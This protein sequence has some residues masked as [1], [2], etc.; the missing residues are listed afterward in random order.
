[1]PHPDL[2]TSGAGLAEITQVLIGLGRRMRT[3]TD[4]SM[5]VGV[6]QAGAHHVAGA[7]WASVSVVHRG[8]FRTLAATAPVAAQADALQHEIGAGP[9]VDPA[10]GEDFYRCGD[11]A[12]QR[13]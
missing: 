1:M 5:L 2:H 9:G 10:P 11:L 4:G 13:R 6:A 3:G 12:H 7:R 8:H